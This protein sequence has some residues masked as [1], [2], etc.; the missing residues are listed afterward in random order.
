MIE[1]SDKSAGGRILTVLFVVLLISWRQLLLFMPESEHDVK[2]ISHNGSSFE[3][4]R[5]VVH[6]GPQKT[7]SS[8]IQSFS[9]QD[10]GIKLLNLDRYDVRHE[11]YKLTAFCF[12]H[13]LSAEE[14]NVKECP[15][16][17]VRD[18]KKVA[19]KDMNIFISA[20]EYSFVDAK[21]YKELAEFLSDWDKITIMLLY[22]RFYSW[23]PSKQFQSNKYKPYVPDGLP[24]NRWMPTIEEY[25][26]S[27]SDFLLYSYTQQ[28]VE[29]LQPTFDDI[30]VVDMNDDSK[31]DIVQSF[32]C[33]LPDATNTCNAV[34]NM[35]NV[36]VH[37]SFGLEYEDIARAARKAVILDF[38]DKDIPKVSQGMQRY[39]ED[40]LHMA[41]GDFKMMCPPPDVLQ[42]IWD[43]SLEAEKTLFPELFESN[44]EHESEMRADF[45]IAAGTKLC[46]VD[47]DSVLKDEA[48]K[49]FFDEFHL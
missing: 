18:A 44:P 9:R 20:E 17:L 2:V 39:H 33:N 23:L 5:A 22:R 35:D 32:Y 31:G 16:N 29:R 49:P 25:L 7:A 41:R 46:N 47:T 8:S 10:N 11:A 6:M 13:G 14:Y 48:W 15:D 40:V 28:I 38:E 3:S 21:G 27:E 43:I 12:L 42:T 45:D 30:I 34:Q 36:Q 19:S 24:H 37:P 26:D 4:S 1:C